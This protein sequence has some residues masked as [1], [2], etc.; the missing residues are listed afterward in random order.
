MG[1]VVV[2][3]AGGNTQ[4]FGGFVNRHADEVT[5]FHQFGL[6]LVLGRE[7]VKRLAH[8]QK[9]VVVTRHGNIHPFKFNTLLVTSVAHG[10]FAAGLVNENAA[11]G[12][13]G[14]GEEMGTAIELWIYISD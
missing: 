1:P 5:Q 2:G 9:L 3:G 13:G 4:N 11:H 10:A 14:G 12:L 8:G 6:D 7:F